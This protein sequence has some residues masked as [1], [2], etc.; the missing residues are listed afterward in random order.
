VEAI[1]GHREQAKAL[2]QQLRSAEASNS[3]LMF[4]AWLYVG[5]GQ[6]DQA[7][8]CLTREYRQRSPMMAAIALDPIFKPLREDQRFLDLLEDIRKDE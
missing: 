7:L 5:L 8:E 6:N 4:Q 2:L 1:S 3:S